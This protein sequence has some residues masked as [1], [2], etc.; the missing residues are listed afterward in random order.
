MFLGKVKVKGKGV[1]VTLA[2]GD[3]N[4]NE[5]NINNYLVHEYHVFKVV[6]ELYISGAAGNCD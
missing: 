3:Y 5:P 6:N 4:P 1:T 2:D